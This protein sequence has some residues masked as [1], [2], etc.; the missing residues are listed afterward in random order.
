MWI[1]HFHHMHFIKV[2]NNVGCK[3]KM[4]LRVLQPCCNRGIHADFNVFIFPHF[5]AAL[6]TEGNMLDMN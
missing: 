4:F 1:Y 5:H 6:R 2:R 3:I